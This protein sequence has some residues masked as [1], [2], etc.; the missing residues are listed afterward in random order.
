MPTQAAPYRPVPAPEPLGRWWAKTMP[1][2]MALGGVIV[3]FG[4]SVCTHQVVHSF[5][6]AKTL[7]RQAPALLPGTLIAAVLLWSFAGA[8]AAGLRSARRR[9]ARTL[10]YVFAGLAVVVTLTGVLSYQRKTELFNT[11]MSLDARG[12]WTVA[13]A[14]AAA[15]LLPLFAVVYLVVYWNVEAAGRRLPTAAGR[16]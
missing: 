16:R 12:P 2:M 1:W 8:S 11:T 6:G 9:T 3:A 10:G 13:Q 7:S 15:W 4:V 14:S 5:H